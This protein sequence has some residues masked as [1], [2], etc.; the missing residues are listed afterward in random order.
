MTHVL[1]ESPL[2]GSRLVIA[3]LGGC[4]RVAQVRQRGACEA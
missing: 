4:E 3:D 2:A 1:G